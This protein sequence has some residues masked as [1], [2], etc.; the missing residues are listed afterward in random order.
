MRAGKS[1]GWP[2]MRW[3]RRARPDPLRRLRLGRANAGAASASSLPAPSA[4][5]RSSATLAVRALADHAAVGLPHPWPEALSEAARAHTADLPDALDRAVVATDLGVDR[6]PLWW[7]GIGGL[8]WLVT[9]V[10]LAGALWL[11]VRIALI[12]IGLPTLDL[13]Q[14]GRVPLATVM[15]VGGL[16]AG[17]LIGL[18]VKPMVAIGAR[19]AASR[20]EG[21]LR[22]AVTEVARDLVVTPVRHVLHQYAEARAALTDAQR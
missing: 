4:A 16:L 11:L 9:L 17:I 18:L 1:M 5:D 14:V 13:I 20:A 6:K 19:H 7:R 12:A 22:A 10:A 2:L 15:L 21:R 3:I 8:Q